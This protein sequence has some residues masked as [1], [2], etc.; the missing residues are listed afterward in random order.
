M[1]R[2]RSTCELD[3][4]LHA[5]LT[6]RHFARLRTSEQWKPVIGFH[7]SPIGLSQVAHPR[8]NRPQTN[9]RLP[10]EHYGQQGS[11]TGDGRLWGATA[12]QA[13]PRFAPATVLSVFPVSG[14]KRATHLRALNRSRPIPTKR[15][16]IQCTESCAE[17]RMTIRCCANGTTRVPFSEI[18]GRCDARFR[19][20]R[21]SGSHVGIGWQHRLYRAI[22]FIRLGES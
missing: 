4:R 3:R 22:D 11:I 6:R 10:G 14:P 12:V 17:I 8:N 9:A 1:P 7:G 15:M 13:A 18:T 19:A 5:T 20:S 2:L 21:M 16:A